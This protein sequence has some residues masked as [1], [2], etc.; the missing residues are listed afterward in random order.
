MGASP[1]I[2]QG[3]VAA[4]VPAR[5]P[6]NLQCCQTT[7]K[8]PLAALHATNASAGVQ[9]DVSRLVEA[10]GGTALDAQAQAEV[11]QAALV[12]AQLAVRLQGGRAVR[13]LG[14]RAG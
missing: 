13:L 10:G 7:C 5:Y 6:R 11:A 3:G 14:G 9:A 1:C 2:L 4:V 8:P 12:A